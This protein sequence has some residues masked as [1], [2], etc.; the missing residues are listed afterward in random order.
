M[1]APH[2]LLATLKRSVEE[3]NLVRAE[4]EALDFS[5]ADLNCARLSG[6]GVHARMRL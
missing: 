1:K 2:H 3:F 6:G 4:G 5:G